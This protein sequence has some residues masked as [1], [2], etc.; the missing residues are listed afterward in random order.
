MTVSLDIDLVPTVDALTA[1]LEADEAKPIRQQQVIELFI[2]RFA[3]RMGSREHALLLAD[4][5]HK[6]VR[7]LIKSVDDRA[8]SAKPLKW[9]GYPNAGDW[10]SLQ[11]HALSSADFPVC[12]KSL[13]T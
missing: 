6:H 11:A 12:G 7:Q 10:P 13:E 1:A 5:L 4:G 8:A 3:A 2:V 9:R